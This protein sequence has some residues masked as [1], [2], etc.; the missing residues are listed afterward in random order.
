MKPIL[1]TLILTLVT[2]FNVQ[3]QILDPV[4]W[5]HEVKKLSG[6]EYELVFKADI[7]D[8]WHLYSQKLPEDGPLPTEFIFDST[9]VDKT[10]KLIGHV[11]E[12]EFITEYD[13]VF[14]MKLNFFDGNATFKQKIEVLDQS[15]KTISAEIAYQACDDER[16]IYKFKTIAFNLNNSTQA[17][18]EKTA[19]S[20]NK[21]DA[22]INASEVETTDDTEASKGLLKI[23]FTAFFLGF[24]V[25]LTPCVFPMI[26]MTVSFFTKQSKTRAAGIKNA[27][28]YGFFIIVIYTLLGTAVSAMFGSNAM[29]EFSTGVVFNTIMFFALVIFAF[30]FLGAFEI[31]LPNSWVNKVD[32]GANKGG[33]LGIFFM[34]LALAVV[35]FSCTFPIA[36]TALLDA[37]TKGGIAPIVSMLGFSSAIA[38]P[39]ALFAF[40]PSWLNSMPKSGGWL[41]TVKVVL[42]FLELAF[43]FKFLSMVDLVL[44]WHFL[45]RE[46]F[47]AIWIAIFGTLGLYLLGKIKL[48]H[49]SPLT[50]ISV[51]RLSLAI[52]ALSFT[53]YMVPGL[54]GAPLKLISGFP[55]PMSTNS[56]SPYGVGYMKKQVN[57]VS[58]KAMPTELPEG[59]HF[60]PHDIIAFH[61]YDT[62][63]AYAKSV[64]KPVML[65]FTGI[66]CV[67]CRKM[68]EQ[69]WINDR[70]FKLLNNEV[71]LISLYV[72]D[73]EKLPKEEQYESEFS[74][75]K[76]RTYGQ[77]WLEFQQKRYNT[78]AQPLY[79]IQDTNGNDLNK[80]VGYMPDANEYFEWMMEGVSKFKDN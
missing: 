33:I 39:F 58:G 80:T 6:T 11:V 29:Y 45:E 73:R 60:G 18:E 20:P 77:K 75:N 23:F 62:G 16:C 78:N 47:I 8:H 31:M 53:I 24:L 54:W 27:L 13:K 74:G 35:S 36:G 37:A 52:L 79:V 57:A 71:V 56:E 42:G 41:N 69:V 22:E 28:V 61:D 49:D 44:E 34:A 32:Q 38:L 46:V 59:A 50:H 68:E 66:T 5:S 30:S 25:L 1:T 15:L 26:P 17:T 55:P 2:F 4:T 64:N 63:L 70:V 48:P 40:F 7:E 19:V 3:S 65:D 72:D 14:D 76:I 9:Q 10:F 21:T 67:N 51:G 43:A 12:S